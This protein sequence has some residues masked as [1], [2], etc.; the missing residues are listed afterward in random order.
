MLKK[1]NDYLEVRK[2]AKIQ[3]VIF[4]KFLGWGRVRKI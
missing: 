1:G 3:R 4:S 2:M